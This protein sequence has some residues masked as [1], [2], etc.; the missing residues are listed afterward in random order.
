MVTE[1]ETLVEDKDLDILL[2]KAEDDKEKE[3]DEKEDS[4][5]DKAE[6]KAEKEKEDGSEEDD[7]ESD[8]DMKES[9]DTVAKILAGTENLSEDFKLR[10]STLFEAHV[11]NAVEE[12]VKL[13]EEQKKAEMEASLQS[14][15]ESLV[16]HLHKYVTSIAAEW[17]EENKLAVDT[18]IRVQTAESILSSISDLLSEHNVSVP[19][20]KVDLYAKL[21]EEK[22][23]LEESVDNLSKES[24]DKTQEILSLRKELAFVEL[25]EGLSMA[26]VEKLKSLTENLEAA[27]VETYKTKVKVV[28]ESFFVDTVSDVKEEPA[29]IKEEKKVDAR[30]QKL[31]EEMRRLNSRN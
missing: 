17:L 25:S 6:D 14:M 18:G 26:E 21:E 29:V 4:A 23:A 5:K 15:E 20:E 13:I 30:Q 16:E 19:E 31:I 28:K 9:A 10:V 2:E 7:K 12:K 22:V 24:L 8:E 27:D 1:L 3:S 11:Q